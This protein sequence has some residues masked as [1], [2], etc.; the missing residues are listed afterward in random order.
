MK[1]PSYE[2]LIEQRDSARQLLGVYR[3]QRDHAERLIAEHN[4]GCLEACGARGSRRCE[5]YTS[6]AMQ[7]PDCPRDWMIYRTAD[8]PE[9]AP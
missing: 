3:E 7:C 5:A 8:Q 4:T 2:E 1:Y 6:R 9:A